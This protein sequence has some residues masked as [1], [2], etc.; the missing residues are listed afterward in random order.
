MAINLIATTIFSIGIYT[1]AN[2]KL[3]EISK[4]FA[5]KAEL[6]KIEINNR[7]AQ[8]ANQLANQVANQGGPAV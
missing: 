6:A 8:L 1:T 5:A 4:F 3:S 7:N 2:G